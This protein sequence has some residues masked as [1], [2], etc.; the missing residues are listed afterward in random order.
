[1][2][3]GRLDP[4]GREATVDAGKLWAGG[5]ATACV[6]SLIAVVGVLICGG[7]LDVRLVRP[8]LLLNIT[9]SFALDYALTAFVLT[10][11]ATA[12]AH[13]LLL[14]T[15]RPRLF[16]TWIIVLATVA[17]AAAPFAIGSERPSQVG[18]RLH[19]HRLGDLC[20]VPT[21]VRD[22]SDRAA[23][24]RARKLRAGR[25]AARIGA[26]DSRRCRRVLTHQPLP[27]PRPARTRPAR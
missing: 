4:Y 14:S 24:R 7:V 23:R 20:A 17:G 2:T 19:Q 5:A 9:D 21:Q 1:M 27:R 13:G 10:L 15:P 6:A 12:L 22:G 8:A 26:Q 11:I 18:D 3:S 25:W 16:F